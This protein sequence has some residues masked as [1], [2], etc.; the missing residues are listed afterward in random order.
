MREAGITDTVAL[1]G[2]AADFVRRHPIHD[3]APGSSP[4]SER[5]EAFLRACGADGLGGVTR[6][7]RDHLAR[8]AGEYAQLVASALS[9]ERTAERLGTSPSRIRRR[10]LE[11]SPYAFDGPSGRVPPRFQ[12]A[13][14][15]VLPGPVEV[16]RAIS[17]EACPPTVESFFLEPTPEL[18]PERAGEALSLRDWLLSGHSA[19]PVLA[20]ARE[21]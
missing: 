14:D 9:V 6:A 17:P 8:L 12:F 11:R 10:I 7:G 18:E 20:L 16:V 15:G 19:R 13:A 21:L 1:I 2:A 5:E 4:L 3:R